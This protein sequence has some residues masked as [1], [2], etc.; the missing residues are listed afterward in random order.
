[1][2]PLDVA[3][4]YTKEEKLEKVRKIL[5]EVGLS[6]KY[7]ENIRMKCPVDRDREL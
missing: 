7:L 2:A 5:R 6:D 3:G 4:K 1:M